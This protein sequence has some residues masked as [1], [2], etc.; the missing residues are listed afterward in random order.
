MKPIKLHWASSK[1]NFGDWLS[2]KIVEVVSGRP[3]Q[4]T[5]IDKCDLV[6]L[7]SLLQRV[8]YRFWARRLHIWGAGFIET[9][10]QVHC[11]H[12]VHAVRGPLSQARLGLCEDSVAL[13]D[14]GLLAGLLLDGLTI[15]KRHRLAIIAHYKDKESATFKALCQA[16]PD[17]KVLDVFSD[18][19]SLLKDIAVMEDIDNVIHIWKAAQSP[20]IKRWQDMMKELHT[21]PVSDFAM[22]SVAL[23]ELLDLVQSTENR[24]DSPPVCAV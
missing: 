19:L 10:K 22:F 20:L 4:F 9:G 16:N 13:G 15:G 14:P 7:G 2:P 17:A 21:A 8:K 23:R 1:P 3:V 11:R 18:P 6:A 12:H 5:T 24:Q